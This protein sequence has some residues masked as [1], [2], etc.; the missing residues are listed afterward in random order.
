MIAIISD[1]HANYDALRAVFE[2]IDQ[3]K[4]DSV[5]CLGDIVG[6]GP[7]PVACVDEVRKRC[8]ITLCGNHDFALIY[9]A[10]DFSAMAQASIERHR[11]M[12]MPRPGDGA[13]AEQKRER[14]AFL[15]D[16]PY[17]HVH[18]HRLMVHASPRNPVIEYLRKVDV[19]LGLSDKI[20]ENFKQMDWLCFIGHTH[21]PGIITRD[22]KFLEPCDVHGIFTAQPH[23]KAIINVGSVGQPRDGDWRACFV[24]VD[25]GA[26]VRYHRVEYDIENA[27]S[28]I[29]EAAAAGVDDSLADRLRRG[30]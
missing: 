28:K 4:A 3:L 26:V 27:A 25:D 21:Q 13:A 23:Q 6:Y 12:M 8:A 16:L 11:R 7:E 22:M 10:N 15:K 18:D 9:G 24:T 2:T 5:I 19:L 20:K 17:R 14:W 30:R 1:I 29:A